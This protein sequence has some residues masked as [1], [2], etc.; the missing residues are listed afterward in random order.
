MGTDNYTWIFR[1]GEQVRD[2]D[3]EISVV[4]TSVEEQEVARKDM[5]VK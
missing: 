4:M 2:D 5:N 3:R 1:N